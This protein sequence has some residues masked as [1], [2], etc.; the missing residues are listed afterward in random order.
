MKP[1]KKDIVQMMERLEG[2]KFL[3][4][5]LHQTFG[6]GYALIERNPEHE[7]KK[8]KKY[9]LRWGK[10]ESQTRTAKPLWETDKSKNLAGWVV[11]RLGELISEDLRGPKAA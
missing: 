11:G 8:G 1:T 9:F 7:G 4:F 6:G 5:R 10:D 3:I 2:D